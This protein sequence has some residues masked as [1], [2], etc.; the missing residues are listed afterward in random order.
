MLRPIGTNIVIRPHAAPTETASGLHLVEHWTAEYTGEVIA[1]PASVPCPHCGDPV[2]PSVV[3]GDWVVF[4][5][6]AGQELR[7]DDDRLLLVKDTD[8]LAVI[9]REVSHG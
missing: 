7:L 2:P 5:A 3:A 9:P 6:E 1:V 4:P 8:L